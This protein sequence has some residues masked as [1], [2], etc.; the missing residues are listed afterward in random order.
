MKTLFADAVIVPMTDRDT[1]YRYMGIEGDR[2]IYLG[3]ALPEVKYDRTIPCPGKFIYPTLCDSH[4]HLLYS[5][6]L[7]ASSFSVC[8]I[9]ENGAEPDCLEKVA[10]LFRSYA[11][12]NPKG[13]IMANQYI[14]SVIREERLPV[15]EELD[16]WTGG[17][18]VV[19]FTIDGHSC[20]L[21]TALSEK[22][23]LRTDDGILRGAAYDMNQGKIT[24]YAASK[25]NLRVLAKG[26]ANFTNTCRSFGIGKVCALDG[27][28]NGSGKDILL[29][30]LVFLARRMDIKVRLYP[31][32]MDYGIL[33]KL[34]KKMKAK[35]I[36]GCAKWELDGS[37]GSRSAAFP[38]DFA[39][40]SPKGELYYKDEVI[41]E[42]IREGLSAGLQTTCHAI[43]TRA[44]DQ[45][46]NA[47]GKAEKLIPSKGA[48]P[49]IDHFEFP[50]ESAL[51]FVT[52]HRVAVTIQPGYA[53]LDRR[54]I[55]SYEKNLDPRDLGR[56]VPLRS[57]AEGGAVLLG[58]SDSPVQSVDP[59][60]QM[61][62][63]MDYYDR[64][65]S[66]SA[67]EAFRTYTA[68]ASSALDEAEG[69]LTPGGPADFFVTDTDILNSDPASVTAVRAGEVYIDGKRLPE[70]TGTVMEF[71]KLIFRSPKR[72]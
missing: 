31:E 40:G 33:K 7:A 59:Y 28:D 37:V 72:I 62:G 69:T 14:P 4:L 34:G 35:R 52:E 22:L 44:I 20:S 11:E 47:L 29:S 17:R 55:H 23:G 71:L 3:N 53:W 38:H 32:Y 27:D 2:I 6:V 8:R 13:L 9:T 61:R 30:L 16:S 45:I 68:H 67:Y 1:R 19:V 41:E 57:L 25:V 54:C 12:A 15:A 21:S 50:S 42:K 51:R 26:L 43:G 58:S 24:S 60:E 70:K 65:Q 56:I 63:M 18:E 49:R 36:G 39:D 66:L 48:M 64:E 5:I 10:G 46:V